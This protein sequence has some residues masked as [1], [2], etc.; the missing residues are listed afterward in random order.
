MLR[1]LRFLLLFMVAF[2]FA[3]PTFASSKEEL[4]ATVQE[5]LSN[6]YDKSPAA[7]SLGKDAK[8]ILVFPKIIKGGVFLGGEY[9]EGALLIN[10]EVVDYYNT[11][12]ASIGF[13]LGAQLRSQVI[14]FMTDESLNKFRN[15][16]GWEAGVDG[17]IAIAEFGVGE[18]IA[19]NTAQSPI[20]GFI[21]DNKGLMYNLTLEGT[22][23]TKIQ[24]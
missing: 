23:I 14:M 18:T 8:G 7:K 20:I 1:Q 9:G 22:K 15:S 6:L 13:Q 11:A 19:T 3:L 21:N 4:D 24:K 12:S 2:V 5:S 17:S 10:Q 16:K